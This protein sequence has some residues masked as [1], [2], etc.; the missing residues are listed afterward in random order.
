MTTSFD[1]SNAIVMDMRAVPC[2]RKSTFECYM[3]QGD[4]AG[5]AYLR[6]GAGCAL[7]QMLHILS[8]RAESL[9]LAHVLQVSLHHC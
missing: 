1:T 5:G 7:V 8:L 9:Y 2:H 6:S 3:H 4:R